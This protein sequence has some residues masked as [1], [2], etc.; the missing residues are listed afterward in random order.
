[1]LE[2]VARRYALPHRSIT[3]SA[4][5]FAQVGSFVVIHGKA[6]FDCR[7]PHLHSCLLKSLCTCSRLRTTTR[8]QGAVREAC[9]LMLSSRFCNP[10][11]ALNKKFLQGQ[12]KFCDSS[13]IAFGALVEGC[14]SS[15]D[16]GESERRKPSSNIDITGVS[17]IIKACRYITGSI[18][19]S[20]NWVANSM[21]SLKE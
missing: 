2:A 12:R 9:K 15:G 21:T 10:C 13:G 16:D 19:S 4:N 6:Q 8:R 5:S 14:L 20:L 11:M 17:T 18:R 3:V 7:S 1:M